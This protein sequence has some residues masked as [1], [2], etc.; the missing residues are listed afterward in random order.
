MRSVIGGSVV[1]YRA[2]EVAYVGPG[3]VVASATVW[4]G[5]RAYSNATKGTNAI[6]VRRASDSSE[7]DITTLST[8]ALDIASLNT[9]LSNTWGAVTKFYDKIGSNDQAQATPANQ[10]PL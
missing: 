8:G 3:D 10:A 1:G 2:P 4:W 6:R 7:S 9:F 5:L